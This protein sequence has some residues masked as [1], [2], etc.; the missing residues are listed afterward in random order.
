M[1]QVLLC[2]YECSNGNI[3]KLDVRLCPDKH[4]IKFSF[5]LNQ[6]RDM[7]ISLCYTI[8]TII[9]WKPLV[10]HCFK[11]QFSVLEDT[12]QLD[13][14][15]QTEYIERRPVIIAS[16]DV[17]NDMTCQSMYGEINTGTLDLSNSCTHI[18][19]TPVTLVYGLV[20]CDNTVAI[21]HDRNTTI[22]SATFTADNNKSSCTDIPMAPVSHVSSS[23]IKRWEY[24]KINCDYVGP[25]NVHVTYTKND[26][27]CRTHMMYMCYVTRET[28]PHI[29]KKM[30]CQN[31]LIWILNT[32]QFI[33]QLQRCP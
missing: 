27:Y 22:V 9:D 16:V 31:L 25:G 5:K 21:S 3:S 11:I 18:C 13:C 12:G 24:F 33:L 15:F 19:A 20:S 10:T 30:N 23:S 6:S 26:V 17:S 7:N 8:Q 32:K 28:S 4:Y 2:R 1:K 29:P 14:W